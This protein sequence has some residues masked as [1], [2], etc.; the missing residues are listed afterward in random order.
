MFFLRIEPFFKAP[1]LRRRERRINYRLL[2]LPYFISAVCWLTEGASFGEI[3]LGGAYQEEEEDERVPHQTCKYCHL[4][5]MLGQ[6][7][8]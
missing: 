6:L 1:R 2:S 3:L 4:W 8:S 5:L 7:A